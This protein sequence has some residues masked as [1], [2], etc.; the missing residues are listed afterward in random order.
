MLLNGNWSA[1]DTLFATLAF[2]QHCKPTPLRP[3]LS[4]V[5]VSLMRLRFL[6]GLELQEL[7]RLQ[8]TDFKL[9]HD[10]EVLRL[11]MTFLLTSVINSVIRATNLRSHFVLHMN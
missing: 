6:V 2:S 5:Q 11:N 1:V 10:L 4:V 7:L 8:Q 3:V 9:R